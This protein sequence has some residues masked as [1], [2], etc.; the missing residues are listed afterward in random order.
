MITRIA[1]S[2]GDPRGVGPEVIAKAL[3]RPLAQAC[4]TI[5]G[6]RSLFGGLRSPRLE[7]VEVQGTGPG[8]MQLA[9]LEAALGAVLD[10]EADA[11]CTAP[12][13]KATI[14]EAGFPFPGHTEYLAHRTGT[15][16][17]VMMLAGPRLRVVPLTG[18]L[19]LREVSQRLTRQLVGDGLVVAASAL[20]FDLG[21]QRPRLALAGLNPHAG[22]GGMLGQEEQ[23]VLLPGI[24]DARRELHEIGLPSEIV[25]PLPS[26]TLFVPPVPFDAVVCCYHDQALIPLKL[27]DR[28]QAVNVTLGLPIVRTSPAHGTARDI[29][30]Q[31]RADPGSMRAALEL[32]VE[33]VHRRRGR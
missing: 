14:R 15:R 1:I 17:F 7:W 28:D 6:P 2:I 4:C 27:L 3:A 22:E 13:T 33:I 10:G 30:G 12:I 29:A 5:F 31:D 9:S 16:R 11:L 8:Q 18:H 20:T 19:P 23:R 32:A 26:D 25:G 21:I 24:Q